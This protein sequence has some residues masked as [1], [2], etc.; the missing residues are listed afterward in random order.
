MAVVRH[1]DVLNFDFAEQAPKLLVPTA[2]FSISIGDKVGKAREV[3]PCQPKALS[4]AWV[5]VEEDDA[6]AGDPAHL[7]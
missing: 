7:A 5:G 6:V 4:E 1:G 2:R 3:I